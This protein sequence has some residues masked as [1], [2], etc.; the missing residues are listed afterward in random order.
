MGIQEQ[1]SSQD[2]DQE[3]RHRQHRGGDHS[4]AKSRNPGV[5]DESDRASVRTTPSPPPV[6]QAVEYE[7]DS[8]S[9][10]SSLGGASEAF[11]EELDKSSP[12]IGRKGKKK[13]E[14][15]GI[16]MKHS[17]HDIFVSGDRFR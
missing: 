11:L 10:P 16:F 3:Q 13:A 15:T 7:S 1:Q 12:S 14:N 6:P 5:D 8:V 17:K 4:V 9:S 2:Q